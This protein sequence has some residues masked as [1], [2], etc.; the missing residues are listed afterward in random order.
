MALA[1][2]M[3]AASA[4][5][6]ACWLSFSF[7]SELESERLAVILLVQKQFEF[8]DANSKVAVADPVELI[9]PNNRLLAVVESGY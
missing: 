9:F 7:T 1:S 4:V 2:R 8:G 5:Q 3:A 6:A